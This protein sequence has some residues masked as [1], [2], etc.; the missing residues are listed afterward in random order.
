MN[1]CYIDQLPDD[2]LRMIFESVCEEDQ[3]T[4]HDYSMQNE[5]RKGRYW[6]DWHQDYYH[7]WGDEK[8][9]NGPPSSALIAAMC[10]CERWR[11]LI[12][13]TPTLWTVLQISFGDVASLELVRTFLQLSGTHPLKITLL[14]NDPHNPFNG[15][16]RRASPSYDHNLNLPAPVDESV[17]GA[18][19]VLIILELYVHVHRWREFTMRT[20]SKTHI[21]QALVLMSR[22]S[23]HL[24]HMLEKLHLELVHSQ[25]NVDP[26]HHEPSIFPGSASP[27]N[28]L[29]L[30]GTSWSWLSPSMFSS[31]LVNLQIHYCTDD[32]NRNTATTA[33]ALLQLLG[34]LVNLQTLA[35][36]LDMDPLLTDIVSSIALPRLH[37]LAMKSRKMDCWI[38]DF[39]HH[40]HMPNLRIL[41][42]DGVACEF[43]LIEIEFEGILQE[44]IRLTKKTPS[45]SLLE[46]DELHLV[47]FAHRADPQL[48][49][50]LYKQM[51]SVK[52]LTLGPRAI[53]AN[54][55]FAMGLL[56]TTHGLADFPLPGLRT[57]IVFDISRYIVRRVVLE[58]LSLAGPLEELYYH[59]PDDL[60][61]LEGLGEHDMI[62]PDD[63]QHQVE[64]YHRIDR[65]KSE[66]YCD[67]VSRQWS[68]L[69]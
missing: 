63:W 61:V 60:P 30:F 2:A 64:K 4:F 3:A 24:A 25:L 20:T 18:Y 1:N 66:R 36:E 14:W 23:V 45:S 53:Y 7:Y 29:I 17:A 57:L 50:R 31:H 37:Y 48:L 68:Y 58:R 51:T 47:N 15:A 69:A 28:D 5:V 32:G 21:R 11:R 39:F 65:L 56:P 10:V 44:L 9:S 34:A 22:P 38:A 40:V 6:D 8:E 55:A 49:H 27:I 26:D 12:S 42:L 54:D 19:L 62:V 52:V 35:L 67:V 41:T 16:P 13:Q 33:K 43:M 59:E 46:L